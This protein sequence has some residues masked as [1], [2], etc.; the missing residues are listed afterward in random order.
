MIVTNS[1][2]KATAKRAIAPICFPLEAAAPV[3]AVLAVLCAVFLAP[4]VPR[5]AEVRDPPV[6]FAAGLLFVF[7]LLELP[8]WDVA[9]CFTS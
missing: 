7:F 1:R 9:I 6:F 2:N 8:F 5:G 4:E 3:F